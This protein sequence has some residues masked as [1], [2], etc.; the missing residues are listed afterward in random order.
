MKCKYNIAIVAVGYNRK[1]SLKRLL[2]SVCEADYTSVD[3]I[4][5]IV[6]LDCSNNQSELVEMVKKI[7]WEH[8]NK[9]IKTYS[10]RQGLKQHIL[11]CGDLTS[12]YDA[13]VILED[14]LTVSHCFVNYITQA[15]EYSELNPKISGIS[16]YSHKTNPGCGRPFE[17]M[18]N[19]YDIYLMQYAQSWGQCWTKQMWNKFRLWYSKNS[20]LKPDYRVPSYVINWNEKSWLKYYIYYTAVNGLYF[21]YPY[22]S[23]S[24]NNSEVGE[25]RDMNST[26]YQV[27]MVEKEFKYRFPE[28][29][30]AI[31]YDAFF[32]RL[33]D[34]RIQIG[35]EQ[36]VMLDLYGLRNDY[37][38][39]AL[40]VSTKVLPYKIVDKIALK[41][42]PHEENLIRKE[43]GDGIYIYDIRKP[44]N[45]NKKKNFSR[46]SYD[47]KA[48]SWKDTLAHG[49]KGLKQAIIYKLK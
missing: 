9:L 16:L 24:T 28:F 1:D 3:S 40:L 19:G 31:K 5:L 15:I 43:D 7:E 41:Y 42:R 14:D 30:Q 18:F 20:E 26:A 37:S 49:I 39:V 17:P 27:P 4:D 48:I 12:E 23:L 33:F 25:H 32:E 38:N 45:M 13:V 34:N 35:N 47:I 21:V 2:Y 10:E 44:S 6:S 29:D 36:C 46:I 11:N 8:G 22:Y